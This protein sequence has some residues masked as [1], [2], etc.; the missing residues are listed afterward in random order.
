MALLRNVAFLGELLVLL[1]LLLLLLLF[2]LVGGDRV[3][4]EIEDVVAESS[5]LLCLLRRFL[6]LMIFRFLITSATN[7]ARD[8]AA[9]EPFRDNG[10]DGKNKLLLLLLLT[11]ARALS[12]LSVEEER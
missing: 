5:L 6:G 9:D 1:L 3:E 10:N 8:T 7:W 11:F 12:T 2:G 4:D